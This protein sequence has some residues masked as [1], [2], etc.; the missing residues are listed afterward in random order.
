MQRSRIGV[1]GLVAMAAWAGCAL[2]TNGLGT[3]STGSGGG[4]STSSSSLGSLG[5]GGSATGSSSSG[6]MA[7]TPNATE[8]CYT[9][10]SGTEDAGACRSGTMTCSADGSGFGPCMGEVTPEPNDCASGLNLYCQALPPA[11]TGALGA[12][13]K[14]WGETSGERGLGIAV[15]SQGNVVVTGFF[16]GPLD[17][18]KGPVLA[19]DMQA[20]AFVAQYAPSGA[21]N[22]VVPLGGAGDDVGAAI[23]LDSNDNVFV[24]GSYTTKVTLSTGTISGGP[25]IFVAELDKNGNAKWGDGFA[26][27]GFPQAVAV[28][29]DGT[30]LAVAGY[31]AQ[32]LTIGS[33][34][35][36]TH[37]MNDDDGFVLAMPT[38]G[39][40]VLWVQ[41]VSDVD[42]ENQYL[43]GVAIEADNTVVVA[44]Q[45]LGNVSFG[46]FGDGGTSNASAGTGANVLVARYKA[47]GSG[48]LWQQ[49]D[50]DNNGNLQS[51]NAVALGSNG[52]VFLAGTFVHQI[53][54]GANAI[55]GPA[56]SG[57]NSELFVAQ[58]D[59]AHGNFISGQAFSSSA[60]GSAATG[61]SV[62]VGAYSVV[63]GGAFA[64][65]LAPGNLPSMTTTGAQGG[66]AMKLQLDVGDG[67]AAL[68]DGGVLWARSFGS[69][70][71]TNENAAVLG[72]A[73]DPRNV[74]PLG[75]S[76]VVGYFVQQVDVGLSTG[77]VDGNGGAKV[78]NV[79]FARLAP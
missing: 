48:T 62:A 3:G 5:V 54:F 35:I 52:D 29:P 32:Q 43:Y 50:G 40:S 69:L 31:A 49:I 37:G 13:G 79:F 15:D 61:Q 55:T 44:G 33:T 1:L 6:T 10:P 68:A 77:P 19:A 8:P 78:S 67:G 72:V 59:E 14:A 65:T 36:V 21:L 66:F 70:T 4:S 38:D 53:L 28:S 76:A 25:G 30:T 46:D 63:V 2:A 74:N 12:G 24:V 16:H 58:L 9:G 41:Q 45:G 42:H 64:G 34:P 57:G 7:C 75:A 60:T 56:G 17:F 20:D 18:G 71:N 23:A 11:C 73:L 22:W 51:A 47:D 27:T 26:G 39:S